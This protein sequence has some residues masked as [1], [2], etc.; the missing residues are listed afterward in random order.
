MFGLLTISVLAA[1]LY[2]VLLHKVDFKKSGSVVLFNMASCIAWCVSLLI[3]NGF[4]LHIDKNVLLWG[5]IYGITQALFI[6]F[7]SKAM[8]EGAVSATTLIGNCSLLISVFACL[9]LW[10]E[11]IS[12]ADIGGLL[13]L[14]LG[15]FLTTYKKANS[16]FT[17]KWFFF[18]LLFLIFGAGVGLVFKAFSKS[19]SPKAADMMIVAS[20]VMII[21]YFII[22]FI[23]RDFKAVAHLI[24]RPANSFFITALIAGALS[25]A[26]NRLNIFLSGEM[27]GAVFFPCFNGGVVVL[28]TVLGVVLLKEKLTVMQDMGLAIGIIGICIIGIL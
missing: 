20:F 8:N 10:D 17:K 2:S 26:Y 13:L 18:S 23:R 7:K 16:R 19:E 6:L 1:S 25:C 5:F 4:R 11:P 3:L 28:S 21:S 24:K 27:I 22:C 12:I 14:M 15:I 9:A